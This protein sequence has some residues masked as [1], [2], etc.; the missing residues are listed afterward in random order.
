MPVSFHRESGPKAMPKAPMLVMGVLLCLTRNAVAQPP[1][2]NFANAVDLTASLPALGTGLVAP[3]VPNT[4]ATNEA[5]EPD[6]PDGAPVYYSVWWRVNIPAG[7]LTLT[8]GGS[9]AC[10]HNASMLKRD[11]TRLLAC[12]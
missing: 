8:V 1:N 7:A 4:D 3:A 10:C 9:R 6:F 2:D 11:V 12:S 5:N